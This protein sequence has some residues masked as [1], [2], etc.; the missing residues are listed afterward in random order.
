MTYTGSCFKLFLFIGNIEGCLE[1]SNN[2]VKYYLA[3][4]IIVLVMDSLL[5]NRSHFFLKNKDGHKRALRRWVK[6]P[7]KGYCF[8]PISSKKSPFVRYPLIIVN[9]TKISCNFFFI[10]SFLIQR[11]VFFI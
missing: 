5:G 10:F 7:I 4:P 1:D 6:G 3:Y 8:S 9:S 11:S 2:S